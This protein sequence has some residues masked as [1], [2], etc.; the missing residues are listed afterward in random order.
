MVLRFKEEVCPGITR[1]QHALAIATKT[2]RKKWMT[3]EAV[4]LLKPAKDETDRSH[5]RGID[6]I[7]TQEEQ[8][9]AV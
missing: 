4:A 9:E 6:P 7:Y 3:D 5:L 1:K 2:L 8:M